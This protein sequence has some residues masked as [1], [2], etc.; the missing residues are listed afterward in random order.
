MFIE[1][2]VKYYEGE[3]CLLEP[4]PA[5]NGHGAAHRGI[6][7]LLKPADPIIR[8]ELYITTY[9]AGMWMLHSKKRKTEKKHVSANLRNL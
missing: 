7:L 2:V 5:F 4:R 6:A 1:K 8:R 9:S 3:F